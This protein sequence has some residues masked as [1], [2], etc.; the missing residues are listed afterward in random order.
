M[1]DVKVL[2]NSDAT[3]DLEVDGKKETELQIE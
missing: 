3:E 1:A 2:T